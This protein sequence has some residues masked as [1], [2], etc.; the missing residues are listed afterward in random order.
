V[1]RARV[2]ALLALAV[3]SLH[4]RSPTA[5]K[6]GLR[7]IALGFSDDLFTSPNPQ[8]RATWLD[9]AVAL[10]SQVVRLDAGWPA[11]RRPQDPTSPSDPAYSFTQ[12]DAA[13]RDAT[14]AG[15]S[16]LLS[17]TGAP[18]WAEGPGRP[19]G[20]S[21]AS[22]LPQPAAVGAYGAALATRYDGHYPDPLHPGAVL[23]RVKWFQL[24]NEPNLSLYLSPQWQRVK[25]RWVPVA[26]LH[27]RAMLKAFYAGVKAAQPTATV[28]TA[29]TAPF[30]DFGHGQRMMPLLFWRYVLAAPVSFDAIAHQPYAFGS[31]TTPALNADDIAIPDLGKLTKLVRRAER[32]GTALP[33]IHHP[34]WVTETGYNT[35]PPNPGGVPVATDARY[36]EQELYLF[37]K[38]GVSVVTW[39]LIRDSP[40]A[41]TYGDS[42]QT[43]MYYLSGRTKPAA[44][45]FRFPVVAVRGGGRT[46][47]W[48]RAPGS[49]VIKVAA[50][51]RGAWRVVARRHVK[52]LEVLEVRVPRQDHDFRAVLGKLTSLSWHLS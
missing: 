28:V 12:L 38:Q 42:S 3:V 41:P 31:P 45:A 6:A 32:R 34:I 10:G 7:P 25:R 39:Y 49:G 35:K 16:P 43:G 26:P 33:H 13:V 18:T 19:A 36:V 14:A 44:L 29:G 40:P 22:W 37:W 27:Y 30:G 50:R 1:S 52:P 8:V 47:V 46:L 11:S 2:A 24:W 9:R 15:I 17:F 5:A 21:P 23:P 4:L 48:L 51:E 20:A